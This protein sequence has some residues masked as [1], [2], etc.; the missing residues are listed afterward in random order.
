MTDGDAGPLRQIKKTYKEACRPAQQRERQLIKQK[1]RRACQ[2]IQK[3]PQSELAKAL[4]ASG[5]RRKRQTE[6]EKASGKQLRAKEFAQ[7]LAKKL[8]G[9]KQGLTVRPFKVDVKHFRKDVQMSIR[10]MEGNKAIGCDGVHVEML[11]VNPEEAARLLTKISQVVEKTGQI[12][13]DWLKGIIVPLYKG[14]GDQHISA[15]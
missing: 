13:T 3:D 12:P 14:K 15:N 4:K 1:E 8:D 7:Y 2:R 10:Q 11:K 5:K 9:P 6:M